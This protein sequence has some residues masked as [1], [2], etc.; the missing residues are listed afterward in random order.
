MTSKHRLLIV[1]G[2]PYVADILVQTLKN[3]FIVTV[4]STGQDAARLLIQGT[5]FDC[6]LTELNLPFFDGLELTKLIRMS[7]L[8]SHTPIVV[9]SNASD[10]NTRIMCL[11][12]GVDSFISKPFNPLEVKARLQA[13]LRRVA[14]PAENLQERPLPVR[15]RTENR[16]LGMLKSRI[17]SMI[18][19][20]Y[21]VSQSA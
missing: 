6:V 17:L 11:E 8:L 9:L 7:R 14:L 12:Q 16:S 5:R 13:V 1:D 10:S 3:D 21:A 4:A 20:D 19:G 18:L 2:N 15:G